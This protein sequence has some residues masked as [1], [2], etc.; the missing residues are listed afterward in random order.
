MPK[1]MKCSAMRIVTRKEEKLFLS[2]LSESL[3]DEKNFSRNKKEVKNC[4]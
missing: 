1:A 2:I 4:G 3:I